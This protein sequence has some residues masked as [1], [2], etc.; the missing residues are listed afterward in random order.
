MRERSGL[1]DARKEDDFVDEERRVADASEPDSRRPNSDEGAASNPAYVAELEARAREAEQQV[2]NLRS[3]FEQLRNEYERQ[4]DETRQRL[5]RAADERALNAKREFIIALLPV[6]D[7]LQRAL[8]SVRESG[9]TESLL[10]G[11]ERT[12]RGFDTALA[13]VGVDSVQSV[14]TLFDP[15]VHEAVVTVEAGDEE[16]GVVTQEY[17]RGYKLGGRLLRP[18]RVQ[19]GS[20]LRS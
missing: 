2:L 17:S 3:R 16:D 20:A 15:E 14:G 8:E 12:V 7:N 10:H 13:S 1:G 9:S 6:L 19:V 11:V 18:A 4:T 5:N